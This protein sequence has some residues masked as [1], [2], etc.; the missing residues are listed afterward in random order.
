MS[1]ISATQGRQACYSLPEV[2]DQVLFM[3]YGECSILYNG[4]A[5]LGGNAADRSESA[6]MPTSLEIPNLVIHPR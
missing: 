5:G 6:K 3:A 2:D 4:H 1:F